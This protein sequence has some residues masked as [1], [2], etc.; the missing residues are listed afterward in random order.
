MPVSGKRVPNALKKALH[1]ATRMVPNMRMRKVRRRMVGTS[2]SGKGKHMKGGQVGWA[3]KVGRSERE[4][5][6]RASLVTTES[7]R[8]KHR[9]GTSRRSERSKQR[10]WNEKLSDNRKRKGKA[11][12]ARRHNCVFFTF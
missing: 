4:E 5:R 10:E 12:E 9:K 1:R 2:D 7:E 3:E 8:G 11:Q 6:E